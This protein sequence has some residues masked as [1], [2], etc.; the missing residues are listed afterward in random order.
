MIKALL[1][2]GYKAEATEVFSH[3]LV[4][5]VAQQCEEAKTGSVPVLPTLTASQDLT[6]TRGIF[7]KYIAQCLL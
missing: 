7:Y 5:V 4:E 1:G 2:M 3:Q 6:R